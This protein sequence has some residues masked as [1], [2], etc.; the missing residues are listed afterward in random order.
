MG[1]PVYFIADARPAVKLS[2]HSEWLRLQHRRSHTSGIEI[3]HEGDVGLSTG[4]ST[5]KTLFVDAAFGTKNRFGDLYG[6]GKLVINSLK[7]QNG[8]GTPSFPDGELRKLFST[9]SFDPRVHQIDKVNDRKL[10]RHA[11]ERT[12]K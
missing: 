2:S 1:G 7:N 6:I 8:S 3:A 11:G 9:R 4:L 12:P 10:A 5:A